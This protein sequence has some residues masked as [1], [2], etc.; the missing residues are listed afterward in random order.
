MR[1]CG[2]IL[3]CLLGIVSLLGQSETVLTGQSVTAIQAHVPEGVPVIFNNDTLFFVFTPLGE[4]K[5]KERAAA[6]NERVSFLTGNDMVLDSMRMVDNEEVIDVLLDTLRVFSVTGGDA[7]VFNKSREELAE[8][9]KAIIQ[10]TVE[11]HR[12][13]SMIKNTMWTLGWLFLAIAGALLAFWILRK[14][15]PRV[16]AKLEAWEGNFIPS[17]KFRSFELISASSLT[18]LNIVLAKGLR[19]ALSLAVLYYFIVYALGI[20][21]W[22]EEWNVKPILEGLL[23]SILLTAAAIVIFRSVTSFFASMAERVEGWKG[24]FIKAVRIKTVEVLSEE[25]IA[26]FVRTGMNIL[27]FG[28]LIVLAYF[29]ITL[30]FSFFEFSQ[31]WAAT[32]IG[33]VVNPLMNVI[34]GFITY[35]PNLFFIA[36]IVFVTR[37]VIKIVHLFFEEL[38]KGTISLPNFHKE[39]AEPTYKIVRFLIIA[40]AVIVIFPYLPGSDS[41]FFQGISVFIGILF[42]LGSTS[43][44]A[45]IV[46]GVVLTYMRPFKIGDRVKIAD[47]MG[48]IIE[49]TLLITRVRTIKNVAITIPNAMVLGSHIIN[50]SSSAT[51]RGLVLHTGVTIGYDVPWRQV[52]ELL[53]SAATMTEHILH[54]P[55]PFVLQTSLDDFYVSYELNAH[56]DQPNSMA[57][58][59]SQLHQNI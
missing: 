59:Y 31:T 11:E 46:A 9:Y 1:L 44:I 19:L 38:G 57:K 2:V 50:F 40:F 32:L 12:R 29:Y 6:I 23:F 42:S 18:A 36:V 37:Y 54:D 26:E 25:R 33:Y 4:F 24:T 48:D 41:P 5:A 34:I 49:K 7:A 39:W 16:Y 43:A 28:F 53:I 51:N 21:P 56:T 47:T 22:T 27:R 13:T 17:I 58:I 45:N 3:V 55:K 8:S 30:I 35:L 15:F 20:I 10:N 14:V 52:H